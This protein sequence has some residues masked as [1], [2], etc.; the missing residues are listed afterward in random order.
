MWMACLRPGAPTTNNILES[1]HG[2]IKLLFV[3]GRCAERLVTKHTMDSL[4]KSF[5]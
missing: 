4:P 1:Y 2:V 5:Y 3:S